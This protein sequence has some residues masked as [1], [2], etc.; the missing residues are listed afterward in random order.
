MNLNPC[1]PFDELIMICG[2]SHSFCLLTPDEKGEK[3][4]LNTTVETVGKLCAGTETQA[5]GL[6]AL[7]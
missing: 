6:L 1:Y 2:L 4:L 3:D 5:H 7:M